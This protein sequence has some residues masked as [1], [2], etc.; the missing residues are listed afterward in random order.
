M[1]EKNSP[2]VARLPPLHSLQVF[3]AAARHQSFVQAAAEL[4]VTHGAVSRQ[5]RQLEDALGLALFERRN[6]AVFLT[7]AGERLL[8]TCSKALGEIRHTLAELATAPPGLAP[9][10]VSCEP[11]IAMRWLIPRLS[12]FRLENPDF[13]VHLLAAGGPVDFVRDR[14]DVALRRS[15]FQWHEQYHME[16]IA[17]EMMGP[18]CTPAN[19]KLLGAGAQAGLR[20]LH[21]RTRA[22]AWPLWR[23]H[24]GH[25]LTLDE[26]EYFEHF[27]LSLQAASAGL[28]VAMG[29]LYMVEDDIR[30]G[31]LLAPYGFAPDGSDYLL[32]SPAAFND[33]PR[34]ALFLAW[35]R[36]E[37]QKSHLAVLSGV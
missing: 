8:A 33:D 30:D 31:R 1:R 11:T 19:A 22:A 23:R 35:V 5:V 9:L 17:P 4:F 16:R 29:S 15:D 21:T 34:H 36:E 37:M 18:V 25:T 2:I 24:S 3:E 32:L 7:A 14:V 10:L 20:P 6:R 28:G 27:Y 26:P 12:R 13:S